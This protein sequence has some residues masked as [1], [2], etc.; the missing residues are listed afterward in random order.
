MGNPNFSGVFGNTAS[1]VAGVGRTLIKDAQADQEKKRAQ[2]LQD[3]LAKLQFDKFAY[4]QKHD[5][6]QDALQTQWHAADDTRAQAALDETIHSHKESQ[7]DRD[8]AEREREQNHRTMEG[9]TRMG[10]GLRGDMKDIATERLNR[11][12]P[13]S[14]YDPATQKTHIVIYHPNTG[15][16][17]P[18]EQDNTGL[19]V[20]TGHGFDP[21]PGK[22]PAKG[23]GVQPL[24]PA[25]TA[26]AMPKPGIKA[27][28][29]GEAHPTH[30]PDEPVAAAGA[31]NAGVVDTPR[32]VKDSKGFAHQ[33]TNKPVM[34]KDMMP[35]QT[36]R[37]AVKGAMGL[38]DV[39]GQYEQNFK[40]M[41]GKPPS[42]V[43]NA[44]YSAAWSDD[45]KISIPANEALGKVD[46]DLQ[47]FI[48]SA[49][50][51][52]GMLGW[53][54]AGKRTSHQVI[55]LVN[56]MHIPVAGDT[57]EKFMQMHENIKQFVRNSQ[58][59]TAPRALDAV[60]GQA[61]FDSAM[62]PKDY[63][64]QVQQYNPGTVQ[65]T[66]KQWKMADGTVVNLE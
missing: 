46:P 31:G 35:T 56:R 8:T 16:F 40:K 53:D 58:K 44:L 47:E 29:D 52:S 27:P 39:W 33:M 38:S 9:L 62:A 17:D 25:P 14:I 57:P 3:S 15:V 5:T 54:M 65:G 7:L 23:A 63:K 59:A 34:G 42:M 11:G 21:A 51:L 22:P 18:V 19:P 64:G 12:T 32:V 61:A 45:P 4:D 48:Q 41:L 30:V 6:T 36:E 55:E 43:D 26:E 2:A 66:P 37:N 50:T 10:L 1:D 13:L 60:G 20:N 28:V 49:H 24:P